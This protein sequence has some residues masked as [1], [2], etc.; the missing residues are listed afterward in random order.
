MTKC[1]FF[2]IW[3]QYVKLRKKMQLKST[4]FDH[5]TYFVLSMRIFFIII[6][7]QIIYY[8]YFKNSLERKNYLLLLLFQL[9]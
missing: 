1:I 6:F 5:E 2:Q 7:I 4:F 3:L 8:N 9:S